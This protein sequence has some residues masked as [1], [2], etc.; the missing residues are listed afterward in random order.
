MSPMLATYKIYSNVEVI[1]VHDTEYSDIMT[2]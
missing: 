1:I 2:W